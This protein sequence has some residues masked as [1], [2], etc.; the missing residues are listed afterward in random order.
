MRGRER[1]ASKLDR[2]RSEQKVRERVIWEKG[3]GGG[4]LATREIEV[5]KFEEEQHTE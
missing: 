5:C 4:I 3:G 2:G 1:G